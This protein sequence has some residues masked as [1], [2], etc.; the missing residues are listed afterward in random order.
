MA[1]ATPEQPTAPAVGGLNVAKGTPLTVTI[2]KMVHGGR[3]MGRWNGVPVFIGGVIEGEIVDAVVHTARKGYLEAIPVRIVTASDERVEPPCPLFPTCGGCQIQHLAYRAQL[4]AKRAIVAESFRRLG[5]LAVDV[6]P[7]APSPD[8]F[9]YRLRAG[10]K[11]GMVGGHRALG[12]YA[13]GSHAVVPVS[14]CVVLHP[15]L[16]A[17]LGPLTNLLARSDRWIAGIEEIE[18]QTTFHS[19][20]LLVILRMKNLDRRALGAVGRELQAVLPLR[21]L[22]AYDR[23]RHRW[24]GGADALEERIDGIVGRVKIGRAHV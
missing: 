10:L 8:V 19:T 3:G 16:Q 15:R 21:G 14:S 18:V 11:V 23:R 13:S 22:V 5:H 6:P 24:V 17:A 9:G 4:D 20:E 12:F 1:S 2:D 7:L